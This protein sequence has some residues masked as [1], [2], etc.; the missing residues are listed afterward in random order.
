MVSNSTVLV[1]LVLIMLVLI[2]VLKDVC[3][4]ENQYGLKIID[5]KIVLV[6]TRRIQS[7]D[8]QEVEP[9]PESLAKKQ[10]DTTRRSIIRLFPC[11]LEQGSTDKLKGGNEK[12]E[13]TSNSDDQSMTTPNALLF[14]GRPRG[15]SETAQISYTGSVITAAPRPGNDSIMDS[16]VSSSSISGISTPSS[17]ITED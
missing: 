13:S 12:H 11:E 7:E 6:K 10:I 17:E 3:T 4:C 1:I 16:S 14:S 2:L 8:N 15:F 5:S 9:D